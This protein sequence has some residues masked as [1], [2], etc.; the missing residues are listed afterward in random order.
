MKCNGSFKMLFFYG[1]QDNRVQKVSSLHILSVL[2]G[3]CNTASPTFV[4]EKNNFPK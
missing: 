1:K 4:D 3:L 2:T